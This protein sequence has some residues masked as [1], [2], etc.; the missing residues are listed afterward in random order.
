MKKIVLL[1][2]LLFGGVFA[3]NNSNALG[4]WGGDYN[5]HWGIDW[6]HLSSRSLAW[7]VYLGNFEIGDK[8][9]IGVGFGYY[10]LYNVIKADASV[11]RFPL[12]IGPNLG[13]GYWSGDTYNGFDIGVNIT[14][15]ISWFTPTTPEMDVSVELGSPSVG[16]WS[17]KHEGQ[18]RKYDPGFGLKSG[19]GLRVLFHI[20]F[21]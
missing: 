4:I 8:T 15:G 9:S 3:A 19:L 13:L 16:H 21:F 6:K 5:G 1:L 11:G 18:K 10:F 12:H 17:E 14:G 7:D 2:V 20:Y